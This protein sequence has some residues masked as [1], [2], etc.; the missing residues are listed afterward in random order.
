MTARGE[1]PDF[2]VGD[3]FFFTYQNS[4]EHHTP[5]DQKYLKDDWTFEHTHDI[6]NLYLVSSSENSALSNHSPEEKVN[7]YSKKNQNFCPKRKW[8]YE[9][10]I[11]GGWTWKCAK[12]LSDYV[13]EIVEDFLSANGG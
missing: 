1:E 7:R 12:K 9:Q 4:I 6:G 8:M 13:R 10:T 2:K 5:Q 3:D 11:N